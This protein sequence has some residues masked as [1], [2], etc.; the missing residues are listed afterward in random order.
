MVRYPNNRLVEVEANSGCCGLNRAFSR[1]S[2]ICEHPK[3][4]S[5][6]P[7]VLTPEY[8]DQLPR[9]SRLEGVRPQRL[10]GGLACTSSLPLIFDQTHD[11]L[12]SERS[13]GTRPM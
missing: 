7:F 10:A 13:H 2:R 8:F 4:V 9:S 3:S 6:E 5:R 1:S 12:L 11:H